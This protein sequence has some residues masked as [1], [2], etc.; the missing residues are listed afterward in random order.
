MENYLQPRFH[1]QQTRSLSINRLDIIHHMICPYACMTNKFF[2]NR[3][4]M[5]WLWKRY[6][7]HY[8]DCWVNQYATKA[9]KGTIPYQHAYWWLN[10]WMC[11]CYDR[12]FQF[13]QVEPLIQHLAY[14]VLDSLILELFP[15]LR[16][17]LGT[18]HNH[19]HHDHAHTHAQKGNRSDT[20][21]PSSSWSSCT[22]LP[23]IV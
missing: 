20:D 23:T 15:E 19:T 4:L 8:D 10:D 5:N 9:V 2:F 16:K 3:M 6:Q 13:C 12:F 7:Y 14:S 22:Y 11:L 18:T 1:H 21:T 17:K